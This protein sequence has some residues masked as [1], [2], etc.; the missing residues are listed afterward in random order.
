VNTAVGVFLLQVRFADDRDVDTVTNQLCGQVL[1]GVLL[2]ERRAQY[3]FQ[4]K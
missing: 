1:D 2:R 4:Q 3:Q